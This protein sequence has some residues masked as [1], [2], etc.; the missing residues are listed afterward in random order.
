MHRHVAIVCAV[1]LSCAWAHPVI[2]Q[3]SQPRNP[4][5]VPPFPQSSLVFGPGRGTST[6]APDDA[7]HGLVINTFTLQ[8]FKDAQIA[9]PTLRLSIMSDSSGRFRI[10]GIAHGDYDILVRAIG[11]QT[12][13]AKVR[14]QGTTAILAALSSDAVVFREC[15]TGVPRPPNEE[16]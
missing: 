5:N 15:V 1:L 12:A 7:I 8:P 6:T 11:F 9:I 3:D 10:A 14:F 13:R 16:L 4:C 2:A